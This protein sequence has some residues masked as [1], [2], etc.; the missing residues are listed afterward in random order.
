MLRVDTEQ[1]FL[2]DLKIGV[3]R[4]RTYQELLTPEREMRSPVFTFVSSISTGT[5]KTSLDSV[6]CFTQFEMDSLVILSGFFLLSGNI[7]MR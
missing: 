7:P 2:P 5:K 4:R 1:R 6:T 3:W